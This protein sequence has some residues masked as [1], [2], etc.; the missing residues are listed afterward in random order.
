MSELTKEIAS[1]A[2]G[3]RLS[4]L[5]RHIV[6]GFLMGLHRGTRR[7]TGSEFSQYRSYQPGDDIRLID[8]KMYG[9][10]DRYYIRE[11]DVETSVTLRLF[12]DASA[13]M[14]YAENGYDRFRYASLIIAVLGTLAHRQGDAFALHIVNDREQLLLRE[15]RDTQHLNRFYEMIESAVCD[16]SWPGSPGW[17]YES[18][19]SGQRE[20]WVVCSDML[21][22]LDPWISFVKTAGISGSETHFLQ[23]LGADEVNLPEQKMM[24]VKDPE[25]RQIRN[26]RTAAV[27]N[28]Y[29]A[30]LEK[31]LDELKNRVM[32]EKTSLDLVTMDTPVGTALRHILQRR[33][34]R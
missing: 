17:L 19:N 28:Q 24:T 20:L 23:I 18:L 1:L 32:S 29:Q 11:A 14:R 7:G 5:A 22:G 2:S 30:N 25:Q 16:G 26:I 3:G 6:D 13:S 27:R 12:L 9:R 4:I 8:W 31:Y 34:L 10:S 33:Q 15:G 21:D